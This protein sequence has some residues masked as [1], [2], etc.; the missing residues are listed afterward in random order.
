M[1]EISFGNRVCDDWNSLPGWVVSGETV[2]EFRGNL[3]HYLRDNRGF[4]CP[5]EPSALSSTVCS[6]RRFSVN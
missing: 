3:D 5:L 2:N 4:K 6:L 1:A